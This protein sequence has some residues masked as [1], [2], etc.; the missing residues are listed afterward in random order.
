MPAVSLSPEWIR[1]WTVELSD[2]QLR[3]YLALAA[4]YDPGR[5][6]AEPNGLDPQGLEALTRSGLIEALRPGGETPLYLLLHL[7][8]NG[9]HQAQRVAP[10]VREALEEHRRMVD[11]L[12]TAS[13]QDDTEEQRRRYF[14]TYPDLAAEYRFYQEHRTDETPPWRLWME[15]SM[16]LM[17]GFEER[18][19]HIKR[20]RQDLFR[21]SSAEILRIHVE[22]LDQL[23]RDL[24][25]R[26]QDIF[27]EL[28]EG[29]AV[30]IPC[31]R[32]VELPFVR[33][34][35]ERSQ[36]GPEQIYLTVREAMLQAGYVLGRLDEVGKLAD[37]ELPTRSGLDPI[38]EK[39]AFL[40]AQD[41]EQD[42]EL[43]AKPAERR[44]L[45][46][47]MA[48]AKLKHA[49]HLFAAGRRALEALEAR[50]AVVDPRAELARLVVLVN[51]A[52]EACRAEG[53][54]D[55]AGALGPLSREDLD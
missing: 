54:P 29:W 1:R 15:L 43:P 11:E 30:D 17:A 49:R 26:K 51:E 16:L 20:L 9:L 46:R 10:G 38:E 41:L 44:E 45:G 39:W 31:E 12:C 42:G 24:L 28:G 13:N 2:S 18:F 6:I 48:A 27:P 21:E 22:I 23:V 4:Q 3:T 5:K 36:I 8:P 33:K 50:G 40:T 35:A 55:G 32:F 34:L 47:R 19:G 7:D 53:L 25:R 14:E 52:T 37:L